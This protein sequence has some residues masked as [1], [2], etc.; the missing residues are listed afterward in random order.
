MPDNNLFLQTIDAIYASSMDTDTIPAAL[1]VANRL[2][3]G[4]GATFEI[5][6]M[7]ARRHAQFW[8]V[9]VPTFG[10][11]RYVE[12]FAAINPRISFVTRQPGGTVVW[13]YRVLDEHEM[14]RNPFYA[15][16]LPP[17]GLRYCIGAVL[18]RT[19]RSLVAM[20]VQRTP[21]Q[22]HADK[23]EIEIMGRLVPHLQ[24]AHDLA[25]R[26]KTEN[27]RPAQLESTL[28]WLADGIALLRADGTIIYANN[29]LRL[30]AQ[31]G[32]GIRIANRALEFTEPVARRCY[33]AALSAM[34]HLGDPN[35]DAR[36]TDFPSYRSGGTPSYI[37]SVRPLGRGNARTTHHPEAAVMLL[38]HD[39]LWRNTATSE[40]LKDLFSL[41]NAEAH[42][43]QA[44]CT[45]V[46][47]AAYAAERGVSLNTV[48]SHLKRIREKTGCKSVPDLIRKFGELNVPVRL[49]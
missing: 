12:E 10:E 36:P 44:L 31:R 47:T 48:Y 29:M 6:D 7:K 43:A 17:L 34:K 21:K 13:D 33:A 40:I 5:V 49:S 28:E 20:S 11:S 14:T 23:R 25:V 8:S 30:F 45:G 2:L 26:L 37:V 4:R 27:D 32:D 3:G 18:K 22:G 1:E 35:S 39:P 41:T 42:L 15:E 24:R 16:F 19:R 9:G 46:T 38:I